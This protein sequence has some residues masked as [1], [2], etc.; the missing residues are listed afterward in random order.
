MFVDLAVTITP[1]G[2]ER[3][4][5]HAGRGGLVVWQDEDNHLVFNNWIDDGMEGRS[6][7]VFLRTG[8]HEEMYDWD[9]VWS[10][11]DGRIRHGVPYRLRVRTDG[12]RFVC[13]LDGEP[14]MQR[15]VTDFRAS[16]RPLTI[17]R[18]GLAANWEWGDDTGT[19]FSDFVALGRS[20]AAEP[21][22]AQPPS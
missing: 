6:I 7:S 3:G 11:V 9:A 18:V 22:G 17:R 15:A 16:A 21:A 20:S 4:E 1:P 10:N 12:D 13:D 19:R 2:L 8:G 14:V 5:G